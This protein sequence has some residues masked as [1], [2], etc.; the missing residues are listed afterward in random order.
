MTSKAI[1]TF[2]HNFDDM[3]VSDRGIRRIGFTIIFV[4]FG[5]F[6]TWAAVAPLS[7]AVHGS[8][9]VTVQSYRKT[10]QHL[11]GGIIKELNA[12]DGDMVKQG[13]PLICN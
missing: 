11:E 6:G 10:V 12:R 1:T 8:G 3:P 5:I 13:D 2:D 4:T 9:I 7:N